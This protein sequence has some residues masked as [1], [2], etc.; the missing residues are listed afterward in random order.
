[1]H[2]PVDLVTI[3]PKTTVDD[4][5]AYTCVIYPHAAILS[6]ES[7]AVLKQYAQRGGTVVFGCRTGYKNKHG[8]CIMRPSPGSVADLCGVTVDEYTRISA[9]R[10]E[11]TVFWRLESESHG[12][13]SSGAFN[14][15]L[16]VDSPTARVIA[17][18]GPDAGYYSGQPVLVENSF[19]EGRAC[20]FGGV[21]TEPLARALALHL[22]IPAPASDLVT[23][24][25]EV[26][27]AIREDDS[28]HRFLFLLNYSDSP[29]SVQVHSRTLDLISRERV[30]GE[31]VLGAYDV[32][33]LRG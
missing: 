21:F 1:M 9:G 19:G 15:I 24:P 30:G 5:A 22:G 8:H 18:Y 16:H 17:A 28:G 26:E 11:P 12:K 20:Y 7:A 3:R 2:V 23:V 27:L 32:A 13:L 14:E 29:K 6:E 4:L 31:F 25:S 10:K 33:V